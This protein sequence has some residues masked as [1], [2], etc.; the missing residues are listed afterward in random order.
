MARRR[1]LLLGVAG[2]AGSA[3]TAAPSSFAADDRQA[4]AILISRLAPLVRNPAVDSAAPIPAATVRLAISSMRK[5]VQAS[6]YEQLAHRIPATITTALAGRS[7]LTGA[8]AETAD[9]QLASL[10]SIASEAMVKFG[11]RELAHLAAAQASL[12]AERG[13]DVFALAESAQMR[14]ILARKAGRFSAA[15][16]EVVNA[17]DR[18]GG[19]GSPLTL[20]VR[21]SLLNTAGYTA[22][23]AGDRQGSRDLLDAAAATAARLGGD[24]NWRHTAFGPTNVTFYRIGSA[25]ALGD[26]GEAIRLARTVPIDGI[27]YAERRARLW[28]DVARAFD[29]WGK[30]GPCLE[31][32]L[33][34]ERT[35]PAEVR[36]REV[37]RT[38]VARLLDTTRRIE[39]NALRRF[40][41]RVG[42][43][44]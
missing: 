14:A 3:V 27:P 44:P 9:A 42:F 40:A 15:V 26:P 5:D 31:A 28:L 43:S 11:E 23:R 22:A 36:S 1:T 17:V 19:D 13:G 37:T 41:G 16:A 2:A 21:G 32:L 30:P 38:L 7:G 18:L 29:H 34:A 10:F 24:R 8:E 12:H 4:A 6:R 25:D 39:A 33:R 35:A 20:S